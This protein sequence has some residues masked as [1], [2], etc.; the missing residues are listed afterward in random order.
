MAW[1]GKPRLTGVAATGVSIGNLFPSKTRRR[2]NGLYATVLPGDSVAESVV[3]GG[4]F[5]FFNI[6][7]NV[8]VARI[9]ITWFPSVAQAPVLRPLFVVCDPYLNLFRRFVPPVFGLDLS[10]I[11]ALLVLQSFGNATAALGAEM[12]KAA[13]SVPLATKLQEQRGICQ[14]KRY[15]S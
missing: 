8:I 10:P 15:C 5:S 11:L 13:P 3:I 2:R 4:T 1:I 9:L 14:R 12:P 6:Y 7:Q